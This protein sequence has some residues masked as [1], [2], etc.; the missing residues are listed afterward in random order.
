M[1]KIFIYTDGACSGNP[2]P[3]GWGALL[4]YGDHKK[5]LSGGCEDSTNNRMELTAVI[6]ALG[7]L[8]RKSQVVLFTDSTYVKNGVTSWMAEWKQN[9]WRTKA[10]K[11]VKNKD[12]WQ[13]LDYLSSQH[14][15]H[16]QWVR[17]HAGNLGNERADQLAREGLREKQ[18]P[19]G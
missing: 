6:A 8:K 4:Q 14:D 11:A 2:G 1:S 3:G 7:A 15:I 17:G 12:L 13:K 5:E 10:K 18:T 9:S 16:W 19:A